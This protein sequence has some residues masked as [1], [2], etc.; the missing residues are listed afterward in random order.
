MQRHNSLLSLQ[1]LY[2]FNIATS[3]PP[4][5]EEATYDEIAQIC[6]LSESLTRRIIRNAMTGY[7]FKESRPGVVAHTAAS[8]VFATSPLLREWAGMVT[9]EM[10][11][12]ATRVVPVAPRE[13]P[14][15]R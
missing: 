3:F 13:S 6:G 11:P 2:R 1:A 5:K 4:G 9:E 12:A 8:K 15:L 7:I 10:W 14:E